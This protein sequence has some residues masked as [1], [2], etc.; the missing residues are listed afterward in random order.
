M[1][2]V[3]KLSKWTEKE[4]KYVIENYYDGDKDDILLNVDHSWLGVQ[5]KAFRLGLRRNISLPV[6]EDFFKTWTREM[7]YIFGFWIADGNMG[8]DRHKISFYS[9]DQ[10]LLETV[11][12]NLKSEHKI[13]KDGS[14]CFHLQ[15]HNKIMYNDLLKLGG[16]PA[17]SLTIQ[18]PY[19]PDEFLPDFVRGFLDGDGGFYKQGG[20]VTASFTGNVDFLIV[21]KEKITEHINIDT[22]TFYMLNKNK[23]KR[24]QKIYSLA[25][26]GKKAIVLGDYIYKN[27]K[28]LRLER[29][30][31]TYK[32]ARDSKY[33]KDQ[34]R[35]DEV[36][37][38]D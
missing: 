11:K 14:K 37:N 6:D 3:I 34:M 28:N 26:F 17:K 25:Y 1:K 15:I 36:L 27:S 20:S 7:A 38:Y 23:P 21:L 33:G 31:K 5:I 29:K 13:G 9:N 24:S 19:V 32:L 35:L 10:D 12:S 8:K 16:I 2:K 18:F 30:H 4:I 22:N